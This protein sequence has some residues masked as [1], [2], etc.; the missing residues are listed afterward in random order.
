MVE[1]GKLKNARF[2]VMR[3]VI[4]EGETTTCAVVEG[5]IGFRESIN[6]ELEINIFCSCQ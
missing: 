3:L 5:W 2:L 6:F 1:Q 4:A